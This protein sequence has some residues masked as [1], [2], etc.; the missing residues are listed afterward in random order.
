MAPDDQQSQ[1][2]S[3]GIFSSL[4]HVHVPEPSD[5]ATNHN[6]PWL[7]SAVLGNGRLLACLDENGA[8]AQLFYPHIDTGPHIRSFLVGLQIIEQG[9]EEGKIVWLAD[10]EWSHTLSY[11]DGAAVADSPPS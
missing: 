7:Y 1:T 2:H 9:S 5:Q 10:T 8:L 6:G 11:V 4:P 3:E